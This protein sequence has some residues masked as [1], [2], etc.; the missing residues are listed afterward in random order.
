M[1]SRSCFWL[2]KML[3]WNLLG[4]WAFQGMDRASPCM[5]LQEA[6]LCS[7][8]WCFSVFGLT[9]CG[10]QEHGLTLPGWARAP[11]SSGPQ[12]G[13]DVKPGNILMIRG[14]SGLVLTGPSAAPPRCAYTSGREAARGRLL[15]WHP[16][17]VWF[18]LHH[19]KVSSEVLSDP[20]SIYRI[21]TAVFLLLKLFSPFLHIP[22][23]PTFWFT[24]FSH[25]KAFA[26]FRKI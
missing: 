12:E 4:A 8:L 1:S 26:H 24:D 7:R 19:H 13:P 9:V 6:F 20:S 25:L 10:A 14:V 16:Q 3:C 15:Q 2:L 21:H 17:R 18:E 5:A 23:P 11:W 22:P